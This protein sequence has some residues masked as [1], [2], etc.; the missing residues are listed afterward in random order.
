MKHALAILLLTVL[1]R[2]LFF[3]LANKAYKSMSRMKVFGPKM[4]EIRERH[5]EDPA[6]AQAEMMAL[7]RTEKINPASGCLPILIQIPVFYAL[8]KVLTVT[9]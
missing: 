3:P 4:Q 2:G 7:Y 9:V 8:Y 6:K 5:K 1:V